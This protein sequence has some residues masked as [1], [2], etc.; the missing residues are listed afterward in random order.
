MAKTQQL[1]IWD[2]ALVRTATL[3]G[4]NVIYLARYAGHPAV[5]R[6]SN[7]GDKMPV[8]LCAVGKALIARLHDHDVDE[9]FPDDAPLPSPRL[10]SIQIS[11]P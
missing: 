2:P 7:I 5:R 8:S 4:T 9:M 3:D 11:M 10:S 1:S 6:T